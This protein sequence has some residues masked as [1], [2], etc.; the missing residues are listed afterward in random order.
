MK[1]AVYVSFVIALTV[2]S[3]SF[4]V[5]NQPEA[6]STALPAILEEKPA[7][8]QEGGNVVSENGLELSS[9]PNTPVVSNPQDPALLP[10]R[11]A[12]APNSPVQTPTFA[13]D[14]T[15]PSRDAQP[16]E[17]LQF[18]QLPPAN[19]IRMP[20]N[21]RQNDLPGDIARTAHEAP[22]EA[23]PASEP[24]RLSVTSDDLERLIQDSVALPTQDRRVAGRPLRLLDILSDAVVLPQPQPR[25]G[26]P[27]AGSRLGRQ[28][29]PNGQVVFQ[30]QMAVQ[31]QVYFQDPRE[32][33][34]RILAYWQLAQSLGQYNLMQK[35]LGFWESV[36]AQPGDE[37][38]LRAA[39]TSAQSLVCESRVALV[40][41]QYA[42]VEAADL[43]PEEGLPLPSD[44]PHVGTYFTQFDN[45]FAGKPAPA[46]G[47]RLNATLPLCREAIESRSCSTLAAQNAAELLAQEYA[48]GRC[49]FAKL[50]SAVEQWREEHRA[51][52]RAAYVYNHNI[53]EYV[54]SVSGVPADRGTLVSMLIRPTYPVSSPTPLQPQSESPMV[55]Q[56]QNPSVNGMTIV[57]GSIQQDTIQQ[58]GNVGDPRF[59]PQTPQ[60]PTLAPPREDSAVQPASGEVPLIETQPTTVPVLPTQ[61]QPQY[62]YQNQYPAQN[63]PR[64]LPVR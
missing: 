14:F 11:E 46:I 37:S 58:N 17:P 61:S 29:L 48:S 56:N 12:A 64:V 19:E 28:T 23:P 20:D 22:A 60:T 5:V 43:V 7:L 1:L 13:P 4:A 33:Q 15:Q 62:Q 47:R 32:E 53:C 30:G 35:L 52:L 57:N 3:V 34:Q 25:T 36:S 18:D 9:F 49:T 44:P 41:D 8:A 16:P 42:L 10:V 45:I 40:N 21:R 59:V 24:Q 27:L 55:L 6:N 39:K 51:F 50:A 26:Q 63:A 31:D 54:V 38:L 2:P